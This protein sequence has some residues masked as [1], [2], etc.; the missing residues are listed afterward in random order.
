[1]RRLGYN[2]RLPERWPSGR[3]RLTRNQVYG[4]VS[5]V[6]IPLSPPMPGAP[7]GALCIGGEGT[8]G[9][10]TIDAQAE[11]ARPLTRARR[12]S[13]SSKASAVRRSVLA[14]RRRPPDSPGTSETMSAGALKRGGGRERAAA[15]ACRIRGR[16]TN[17]PRLEPAVHANDRPSTCRCRDVQ[18]R[19]RQ[20]FRGSMGRARAPSR[21]RRPGSSTISSAAAWTSPAYESRMST[22]TG[23]PGPADRVYGAIR[24]SR[25]RNSV[26]Q[27]SA[28]AR[29]YRLPAS[30]SISSRALSS[31]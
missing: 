8:S 15:R 17:D 28:T 5:G 26:R 29:S 16:S 21:A 12:R 4:N 11:I 2:P 14:P 1:M 7:K 27:A 22:R 30:R 31:P 20:S 13:A 6:R 23:R 9:V 18:V 10:R 3:R 19:A 25:S 24:K